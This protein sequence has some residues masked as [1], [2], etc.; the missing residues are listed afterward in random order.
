[1]IADSYVKTARWSVAYNINNQEVTFAG[2]FR[3]KDE[4]EAEGIRRAIIHAAENAYG[5]LYMNMKRLKT[6]NSVGLKTMAESL[7]WIAANVPALSVKIITTSVLPWSIKEFQRLA[8]ISPSFQV[9]QYDSQFYPGQVILEHEAFIPVLRTQTR[10]TWHHEQH[11][12]RKHGLTDKMYVADICCGIGDFAV[13]V[14]KQFKPSRII[15][16]DHARGSLEY[17]KSV[18][19]EFGISDIEYQYGDAAALLLDDDQFDFVTC[20]HALQI[21]NKPELILSELFRICKPG[22][23]VYITNEKNSHCYGEPRGDSIARTYAEVARL[24]DH[25]DMD[26]EYGPKSYKHMLEAGFR[27]VKIEEFNIT[28]L[29]GNPQDFADVIQSWEDCYAGKMAVDRGDSPEEIDRFRVGFQDHIAA[30]MDPRGYAAWPIWVVSGSK[31]LK[32]N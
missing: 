15:A 22:G 23:I 29:D 32:R 25:F 7:T 6:I 31:P 5:M 20:R 12:L 28:N 4:R 24:F 10:I 1:M 13:L 16:V 11:L 26:V 30:I 9:D 3:P 17:A 8:S 2:I 21:F 27:D 14:Y 18:A 19:R